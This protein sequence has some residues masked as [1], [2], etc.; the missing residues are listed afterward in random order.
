MSARGFFS[1]AACMIF[2]SSSAMRPVYNDACLIAP[3]DVFEGA[4]H[5]LAADPLDKATFKLADGKGTLCMASD[6]DDC[7]TLRKY[8]KLEWDDA[9]RASG[10]AQQWEKLFA[11]SAN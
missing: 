7:Q 11:A 8:T 2:L 6:P 1:L 5:S 4:P 3:C 9:A 10:H